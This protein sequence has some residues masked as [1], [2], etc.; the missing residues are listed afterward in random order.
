ME[1]SDNHIK[2]YFYNNKIIIL[3]LLGSFLASIFY[4]FHFRIDPRVDAKAYDIIALNVINGDGYRENLDKDIAYDIAVVRVGPLYEYFLAGIYK[5]FGHNY[6]FV[7]IFQAI[8]HA[9]TAL[10]VYLTVPLI[11]SEFHSRKKIAL[12]AAAIIGFYPDLIE[13]SAMLLTETLYLFFVCLM[14]YVF[15]LYFQKTGN[16]MAIFLGL[17]SG[18]ATLARPTVLFLMPIIFFF[19]YK[20]KLRF[21]SFLFL[22][23]LIIVFIPWTA[24]NYAIY[25]KIMPFG[26]GGSFNFWIG[27]YHGGNGEQEPSSGQFVFLGSHKISELQGESIDQFKNFLIDHPAEFVKLTFLR[28]NKYFSVIRPMGFWFYQQGIGKLLMILSSAL[29]SMILFIFSLAGAIKAFKEKNA[30]LKYLLA[31]AI[32]TPLIIFI[33][34]VETRYRFQIYPLLAILAGYFLVSLGGAKKWWTDKILWLAI[35]IVSLNGLVD[36]IL[37]FDKLKEKLGGFF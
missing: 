31:F 18:L 6:G 27:N 30:A 23:A 13:I 36:L 2:K 21:Q 4:S 8:L 28:A 11:F 14:I 33:T 22:L 1:N 24:R 19:F 32:A 9:L 10:L 7:W 25:N 12:W 29:A 16:W 15:F 17:S 3:I 34:V 35:F 26:A 37:S 5:V 20:K